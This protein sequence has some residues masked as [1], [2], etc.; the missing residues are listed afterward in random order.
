MPKAIGGHAPAL[1]KSPGS[2]ID[3]AK[4]DFSTAGKHEFR[5]AVKETWKL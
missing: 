1:W 3:G 4:Y 5:K 2:Y